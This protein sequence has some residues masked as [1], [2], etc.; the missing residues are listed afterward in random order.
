MTPWSLIAFAL[1]LAGAGILT[2]MH[3]GEDP[4][5]VE[6]PGSAPGRLV[7]KILN[8]FGIGRISLSLAG[9]V[10][11]STAAVAGA[12][13]D[14]VAVLSLGPDYPAWFP[15]NAMLSGLGVGLG[16]VWIVAAAPPQ[17]P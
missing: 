2:W 5:A 11:L 6:P 14:V 13:L 17:Q 12:A 8:F 1:M 3:A 9:A 4:A 10:W 7:A 16:C 15:V